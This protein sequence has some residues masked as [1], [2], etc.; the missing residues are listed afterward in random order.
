[1]YAESL[2]MTTSD[3]QHAARL[4]ALRPSS[5]PFCPVS[6]FIRH[7][8]Q[9]CNRSMDMRGNFYTRMGTV[10]HDVLQTFL[11]FHQRKGK[12]V[13][14]ADW[15]CVICR[16]KYPCSF[17]NECCDFPCRYHELGL[18]YAF[19]K[20]P[21]RRIIGHID[22]VFLDSEGNYWI[23]DYKS[24]SLAGAPAKIKN[25]G[26]V[27][28]EQIETY[29]ALL[30]RQYGIKVKGIILFFVPRDDP[31]KP[32]MWTKVLK[33]SDFNRI[34]KRTKVYMEQHEQVMEVST[35]KEALALAVYGSCTNYFCKECKKRDLKAALTQAYK[36]GKKAGYLPLSDL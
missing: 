33:N 34:E 26:V 32:V 1:M 20:Y 19:K 12:G 22:G 9:G 36:A 31:K 2:D 35:L 28:K 15:Q 6:F 7:A 23:I 16:K 29:A 14:L 17:K 27:Y 13:F 25:P 8:R 4:K 18:D 21:T 11:G 3:K 10:M 5:L 24:T 30:R